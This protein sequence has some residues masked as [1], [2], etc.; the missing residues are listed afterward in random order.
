VLI[1]A[2][3]PIL[4]M[5]LATLGRSGAAARDI[6]AVETVRRPT[7]SVPPRVPVQDV[8]LPQVN[9]TQPTAELLISRNPFA[10]A[11]RSL[12][13]SPPPS[14]VSIAPLPEAPP[15]IPPSLSLIGVATTTRAD[16][17]AERTAVIAGPADALYFVREGDVV[18]TRYRVDAVLP[19]SVLLVDG[20]TSTSLKLTM[21]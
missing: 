11:P 6:T 17:R 9:P 7:G 20:A 16:G 15:D 2:A 18:M 8:R 5:S 4:L 13:P 3:I 19:D 21:H 14:P 1:A 10:F 12:P